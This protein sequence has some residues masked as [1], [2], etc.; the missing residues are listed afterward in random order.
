MRA[1]AADAKE[2]EIHDHDL[3]V[4]AP[5]DEA[6]DS[7]GTGPGSRG[8]FLR[9][10]DAH[11]DDVYAFFV[12]RVGNRADA[13]DLT[14]A[15]F[16]RAL[17]AWRRFEPAR[18]RPITWL[19][20]IGRN[21]LIDW[22]RRDQARPVSFVGDLAALER[23]GPAGAGPEETALGLEPEVESALGTLGERERELIALRYGAGLKAPEIAE[24]SGLS[25]SNV[26]QIL[27]RSVRR[28]REELE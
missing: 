9:A 16:E 14:Q 23:A 6:P 5:R 19:M 17:S 8:A 4:G 7:P 11:V 27:S 24:L 15:V 28:L 25:V 3:H 13:E 12:Y 22:H 26:Q 18:T 10:Y 21:L 1:I 20:A 2:A